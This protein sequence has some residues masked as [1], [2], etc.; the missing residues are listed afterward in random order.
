MLNAHT[1]AQV[2]AAEERLAAET[3]WDA[4]MQRAARGL[5][6]ALAAVPADETVLVLVGPG[7]NGGDALFAATHLLAPSSLD[8]RGR[9]AQHSS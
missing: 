9:R 8:G 6:D 5:A 7:N 2:R 4:L 3:G 1:V